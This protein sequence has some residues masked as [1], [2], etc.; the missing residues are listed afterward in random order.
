S[1]AESALVGFYVAK[2]GNIMML[3]GGGKWGY[4]IAKDQM[5]KHKLKPE[6]R[7]AT[8]TPYDHYAPLRKPRLEEVFL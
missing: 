5:H 7:V 3:I 6:D 8:E 1:L 4:N 2:I